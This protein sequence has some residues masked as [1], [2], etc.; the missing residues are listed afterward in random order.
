MTNLESYSVKAVDDGYGD[1]KYDGKGVASLIPSFV[2]DFKSK[3]KDVFSSKERK[4]HLYLASEVNERRYV[5][6]DYAM[7]LD[8]NIKW[9]GG[10]NKHLDSRFPVLFKTVLGLMSHSP[11]EEIDTLMM[12]LP[13][14]YDTEER[15]NTLQ[16]IALGEHKVGISMDGNHFHYKTIQVNNIDIKKQPFGSICDVILDNNGDIVAPDLA[17]GFIVLVDIGARTLNILT[18][19][20]LEDQPELTAQSNDGMFTAYSQVGAYLEQELGVIIPDGKL[21]HIIQSKEIKNR[22]ISSLIERAYENHAN[23]IITSLDKLLINSWGFVTK[24][25]FTGGGAQK[26]LL[27]PYLESSLNSVDMLFLDRYSNV[28]G[29]RKYGIRQMN[30]RIRTQ[31]INVKVGSDLNAYKK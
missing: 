31:G 26:E 16:K 6:G 19:D 10:E 9:I 21:P 12:N 8:P 22:D 17:K 15:R 13:I 14:R 5:I 24:I 29:L 20:A 23:S 1:V 3:P 28:R 4:N 27:R 25:I 2:T 18:L 7:K 30:R 11:T